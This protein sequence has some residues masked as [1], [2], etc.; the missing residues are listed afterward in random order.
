MA[1]SDGLLQRPPQIGG[2]H[3]GKGLQPWDL[4]CHM[5]STG[6]VFIDA[7]RTDV[8]EYVFRL[9]GDPNVCPTDDAGVL[10]KLR[11]DCAKAIHNL[12]SIIARIDQQSASYPS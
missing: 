6:D 4:Q 9:K 12:E 10:G 2:A 7:R 3:Y 5:K 11:E 1:R 8:I